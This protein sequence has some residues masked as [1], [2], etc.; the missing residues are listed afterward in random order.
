MRKVLLTVAF[1]ILSCAV[2]VNASAFTKEAVK[3]D[4]VGGSPYGLSSDCVLS[5]YNWCSGWIWQFG[6]T[7]GATWG[8][9]G[10]PNDCPEG[11]TNG[12]AVTEIVFYGRCSAA[13]GQLGGVSLV[14]VD[15]AYCPTALLCDLGPQTLIHCVP[16]DR[17]TV[18]SLETPCHLGGNPFAVLITWGQDVTNPQ[19]ATSNGIGNFYCEQGIISTFPGCATS[20]YTCSG[21]DTVIDPQRTF[22]YATDWDGDTDLD[23]ICALY[24]QPASLGFPYIYYYGYMTNNMPMDVGM[25]CSSPT[26]V[27][28]S[29]WGHVKALYE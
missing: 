4:G 20:G 11:C 16:F 14:S 28:P 19:P 25:D 7:P 17:W 1:A 9:V 22:I 2:A 23:D 8:S 26:A 3:L 10:D 29:S 5:L 6:E 13:P 15:A 27:E 24:G 21:Y 18:F 12:G